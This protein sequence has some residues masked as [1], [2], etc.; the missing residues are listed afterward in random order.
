MEKQTTYKFRQ[1]ISAEM[2]TK[3]ELDGNGRHE[4]K[5]QLQR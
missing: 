1:V 3:K 4:F 2:K 5:T